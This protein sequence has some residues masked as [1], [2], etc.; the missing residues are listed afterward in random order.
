MTDNT[1]LMA[2]TK[3][4]NCQASRGRSLGSEHGQRRA[5]QGHEHQQQEGY[6]VEIS[7]HRV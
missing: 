5:G 6:L 1:K 7:H 4:A 3:M 2:A